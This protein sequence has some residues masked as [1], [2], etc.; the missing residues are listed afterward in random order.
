MSG[1]SAGT[2]TTSANG[3]GMP[4][5]AGPIFLRTSAKISA[6]FSPG[7]Q[8]RIRSQR[9]PTA[10]SFHSGCLTGRGRDVPRVHGD[11]ADVA[12]QRGG[13]GVGRPRQHDRALERGVVA[14]RGFD[15]GG[16]G[17]PRRRARRRRRR[18]SPSLPTLIGSVLRPMAAIRGSTL[19]RWPSTS[20]TVY[21]VQGVGLSSWSGRTARITSVAVDAAAAKS[22]RGS[23]VEGE[24][25][26]GGVVVV[27]MARYC[28]PKVATS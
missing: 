15:V 17:E 13:A 8:L 19:T 1:A 16:G 9:G 18:R 10:S 26:G 3:S 14:P 5:A 20:R 23:S 7:S 2:G 12:E 24:W 4:A 25:G 28:A 11:L 21:S 6:R 27:S 22:G